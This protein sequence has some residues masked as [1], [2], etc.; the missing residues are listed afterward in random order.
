MVR[1]GWT[2]DIFE[3]TANMISRKKGCGISEKEK[4]KLIQKFWS[5][6]LEDWS[7]YHLT[8]GWSRFMGNIRIS[9]SDMKMLSCLLNVQVAK[10]SPVSPHS[11]SP[12]GSV[13]LSKMRYSE[14]NLPQ[15]H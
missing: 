1:S 15:A 4:S 11:M 2:L 6:H 9:V 3:G 8:C 10:G 7:S 14:T 5:E 12:K 13:T